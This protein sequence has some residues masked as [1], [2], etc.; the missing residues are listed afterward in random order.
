M[1]RKWLTRQSTLHCSSAFTQCKAKGTWAM[2]R[3]RSHLLHE[4][5]FF[6][7]GAIKHIDVLP[8]LLDT[9]HATKLDLRDLLL[10]NHLPL[11]LNRPKLL[12]FCQPLPLDNPKLLDTPLLPPLD[13]PELPDNGLPLPR[14]WINPGCWT[15]T[16]HCFWTNPSS[17]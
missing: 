17:Y 2:E 1:P 12:D 5:Q 9:C 11:L 10:D 4:H 15:H 6:L 8:L 3:T 7:L 14:H 13:R 16:N